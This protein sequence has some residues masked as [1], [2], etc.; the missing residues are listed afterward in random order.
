MHLHTQLGVI[1]C[2]WR[3]QPCVSCGQP[4]HPDGAAGRCA[5]YSH[6]SDS[7][8]DRGLRAVSAWVRGADPD[9]FYRRRAV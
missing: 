4:P 1:E 2:A 5:S 6:P 9:S 8:R 7:Q 3:G